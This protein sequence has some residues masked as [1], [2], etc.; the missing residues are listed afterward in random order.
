MFEILGHLQYIKI[1]LCFRMLTL[2]PYHFDS[3]TC[4][5]YISEAL[6][7]KSESLK[8]FFDDIEWA[9]EQSTT[10]KTGMPEEFTAITSGMPTNILAHPQ[11]L[12]PI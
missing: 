3:Y 6:K 4:N 2:F 11:S 7:R 10:N 12:Q 9:L 8:A 1:S 5:Y